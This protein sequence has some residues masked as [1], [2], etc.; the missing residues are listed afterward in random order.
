[1]HIQLGDLRLLCNFF[2]HPASIIF[3]A[4]SHHHHS[5]SCHSYNQLLCFKLSLKRNILH[6]ENKREKE[7]RRKS[8]YRLTRMFWFRKF[9]CC[10]RKKKRN[11]RLERFK[12]L[13]LWCEKFAHYRELG[14]G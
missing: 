3:L 14:W 4:K 11:G 5:A 7:K 1:M 6:L 9:D 13:V 8:K 10:L 12:I 2:T